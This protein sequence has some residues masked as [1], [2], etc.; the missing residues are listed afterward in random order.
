MKR[1]KQLKDE[2]QSLA[3]EVEQEEEYLVNNLQKRL[4][5]LNGEKVDL[6]NQLEIEQEYIVNKLQKKAR[7]CLHIE[8]GPAVAPVLCPDTFNCQAAG[9]A[10]AAAG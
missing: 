7:G 10:Q 2:K 4:T 1:L 9:R 5:K 6:E 8:G 3:N